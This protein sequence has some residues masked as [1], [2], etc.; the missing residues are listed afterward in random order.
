MRNSTVGVR[1]ECGLSP[2]LFKLLLEAVMRLALNSVNAGR[3]SDTKWRDTEQAVGLD[4]AGDIDLVAE[5]PYQM[6]A[7]THRQRTG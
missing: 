1:Q 3:W 5:S 2:E 6:R 7:G 4:F